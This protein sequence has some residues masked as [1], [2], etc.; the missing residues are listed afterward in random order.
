MLDF[1]DNNM[2]EISFPFAQKTVKGN[3]K[4]P[5]SKSESNRALMIAAYGEFPLEINSLSDANDTVLL[6]KLLHFFSQGASVFDCE[7][8]GTVARFLM[9]FL[10]GKQGEWTL[11]GSPR[12][13]Q[14]PMG[15]LVVALRHLGASIEYLGNDDCLPVK[16][17]GV[18][19]QGGK[20]TLNIENSSQFAS[21]LLLAAPMWPKGLKLHLEGNLNSL[22]YIDMTIAMMQNVG[23][24][25]VRE[26]TLI[27]VDN[28]PYQFAGQKVSADW[29]AAS[30]WFELAA[31]S[32]DCDLLLENLSFDSLQ[33]DAAI[34]EMMRQFGVNAIE[35]EFGIRL[36]KKHLNAENL[37]FDFSNTPDLFP[38]VVATCAGLRQEAYFK[39]VKNL[40]L[41]E[42]DR[43]GA[44]AEEL[45]K[46]GVILLRISED[47]V[48]LSF[49]KLH[50]SGS[51]PIVFDPHNDHR[52]AMAIAPLALKIGNFCVINPRVVEKSYPFFWREVGKIFSLH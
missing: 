31:L 35:E 52:I 32:D 6:Q 29:S 1:Q 47:E 23:A 36:K 12:L 20:V 10:A 21:S 18:D 27:S 33:G 34:A 51:Q 16:I 24:K 17:K 15:D 43:V 40:G 7:D 41:K 3:V 42:S 5:F 14:R 39:G 11:T 44:M 48:C 22:P 8:A 25:V 37:V 45:G 19:I 38:A 49:E 26:K 2:L 9:T 46:I 4:L 30:Y 28:V 13:C 50:S